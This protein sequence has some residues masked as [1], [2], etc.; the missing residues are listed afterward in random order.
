YKDAMME[1]IA[2]QGNGNHYY[3]DT[4]RQA[5][6]V[7]GRDLTKMLQ[8]VA[9]DVKVQV[10]FDP[11]KVRD[12]RL[13]GYENR[14]IADRDFRNDKVDAG[15]IGAGHQVTAMYELT[16]KPNAKGTFATVRV[17]AKRPRGAH[18]T[19]MAM[20][21]PYFLIDRAFERSPADFRF[22]TA[23]MGGSELL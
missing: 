1:K 4:V 21:V 23:V 7:F 3:V 13:V 14:D 2:D 12:Y 8:N 17:R 20:D 10:D 22:A 5:E 19:E 9:Q 16:M 15:E 6:R 18:A 11:S